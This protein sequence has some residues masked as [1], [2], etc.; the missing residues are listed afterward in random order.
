VGEEILAWESDQP[1][2]NAVIAF[3]SPEERLPNAPRLLVISG[4]TGGG[5][6]RALR[7]LARRSAA[8]S[9]LVLWG[10]SDEHI[11]SPF[12]PF[13]RAFSELLERVN[14]DLGVLGELPREFAAVLPQFASRFRVQAEFEAGD[15]RPIEVRIAAAV[16]A[17][18]EVLVANGP[19]LLIVEDLHHASPDTAALLSAVLRH[20]SARQSIRCAV[21]YNP[22]VAGPSHPAHRLMADLLTASIPVSS[23]EL[24]PLSVEAIALL[25][26]EIL[27]KSHPSRST[28]AA[29]VREQTSGNPLLSIELLRSLSL[30]QADQVR[31]TI[32]RTDS[33]LLDANEQQ[34]RLRAMV[35]G[36]ITFGV[37]AEALRL[38]QV[39]AVLGMHCEIE[40]LA[41]VQGA[42]TDEVLRLLGGLVRSGAVAVSQRSPLR[43]SFAHGVVRQVLYDDLPELERILL[44]RRSARHLTDH[45]PLDDPRR[46]AVL[47]Y[48]YLKA[49]GSVDPSEAIAFAIAAGDEAM[50]RSA[51][52]DAAGWF[53]DA[54]RLCDERR[55]QLD[56][57]AP[58]CQTVGDLVLRR[59][60]AERAHG[61]LDGRSTLLRAATIGLNT[62]R[63]DIVVEASLAAS[64]GFFS[65]TLVPDVAWIEMLERAVDSV[66]EEHDPKA[67]AELLAILASELIWAPDSQRRFALGDEALRIAR[68]VGNPLTLCRVLFRL[69][70][71]TVTMSNTAQRLD[72]ASEMFDAASSIADDVLQFQAITKCSAALI[73][74]GE[75]SLAF[76]FAEEMKRRADA[77]DIP[78]W[79]FIAELAQTGGLL[80][81]GRLDDALAA[82][83][84]AFS[85]GVRAGHAEDVT[86]MFSEVAVNVARW[87]NEL[88]PMIGALRLVVADHDTHQKIG[89]LAAAR[90]FD[91]GRPQEARTSFEQAVEEGIDAIEATFME[92]FAFTNLTYLSARFDDSRLVVDLQNR[93]MVAPEQFPNSIVT[94]PCGAHSLGMLAALSGDWTESER[95]FDVAEAVHTKTGAPLHLGET[96]LERA[97][98]LLRAGGNVRIRQA[99]AL[100]EGVATSSEL[101]GASFLVEWAK[102]IAKGETIR[103]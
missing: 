72:E 79:R 1:T 76:L 34:E 15:G 53:C 16:M 98:M 6:S 44:H 8:Q 42:S 82:G 97:T 56:P 36:R 60:L 35:F 37:G 78:I 75:V 30:Q 13:T 2:L 10:G 47:A 39:A 41:A 19:V 48:H 73:G 92:F 88:G 24:A 54:E 94:G 45:M 59:G 43:V 21:S 27:P 4:G 64:R 63:V 90:L 69:D 65:Q 67:R 23:V 61:I 12:E 20:S 83:S 80:H 7:E 77:L 18:F 57:V 103:S 84:N 71:A 50:Q 55:E 29:W 89:Y 33:V 58:G 68:A 38:L 99:K 22:S 70:H 52:G 25:S 86:M 66:P 49:G 32:T 51:Y 87:K 31:R 28:V 91:A 96:R 93:L 46:P 85:L 11:P 3:G 62:N 102:R 74:A 9:T 95:W 40:T 100:A 14:D 5:K 101:L 17:A 81:T 26:K